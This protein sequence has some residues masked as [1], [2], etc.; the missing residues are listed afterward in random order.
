MTAVWEATEYGMTWVAAMGNDNFGFVV[1]IIRSYQC[2]FNL[3]DTVDL[4]K[5]SNSADPSPK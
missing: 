2:F 5:L 1:C 3:S 4:L